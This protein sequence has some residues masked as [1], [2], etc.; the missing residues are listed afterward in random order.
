[1]RTT[2]RVPF[3]FLIMPCCN[4]QLC[5]VN[6]RYPTYCPECGKCV[7]PEVK[8]CA[9]ITDNSAILKVKTGELTAQITEPKPKKEKEDDRDNLP[10]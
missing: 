3:K 6:P 8:G 10:T 9:T 7:Y 1:M 4:H 2:E 5:W